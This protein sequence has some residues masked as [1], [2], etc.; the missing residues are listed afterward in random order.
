MPIRVHGGLANVRNF[1]VQ[2]GLLVFFGQAPRVLTGEPLQRVDRVVV[3]R[4]ALLNDFTLP[5]KEVLYAAVRHVVVVVRI[6]VV[7]L[8]EGVRR[9]KKRRLVSELEQFPLRT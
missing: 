9:S 7:G 4:D 1:H 6:A 5:G 8:K 2:E 3:G